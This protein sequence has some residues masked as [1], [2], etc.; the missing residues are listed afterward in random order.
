MTEETEIMKGKLVVSRQVKEGTTNNKS[1]K[2][3]ELSLIQAD[4]KK[5]KMSSFKAYGEFL[6]KYVTAEVEVKT[7]E[8]DGTVYKNYQLMKM[9][10]QVG[11]VPE[12][13]NQEVKDV[14]QEGQ[15]TDWIAKERRSIRGMCISYAKDLAIAK[16]NNIGTKAEEKDNINRIKG[17]QIAI[18]PMAQEM[19]EYVWDGKHEDKPAEIEE[20]EE[21]VTGAEIVE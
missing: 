18:K 11:K 3:F 6:N 21:P 13:V 4:N 10:E 14:G 15:G 5:V 16:I 19:F 9:E 2:I 7:N 20:P 1:W 17:I 8:K 12:K